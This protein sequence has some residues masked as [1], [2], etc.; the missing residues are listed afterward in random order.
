MGN[1]VYRNIQAKGDR[2]GGGAR[3][4][5]SILYCSALCPL[6]HDRSSAPSLPSP[7]NQKPFPIPF[8]PQRDIRDIVR[9]G[10]PHQKRVPERHENRDSDKS[11]QRAADREGKEGPCVSV[12]AAPGPGCTR[13][14]RQTDRSSH[15]TRHTTTLR[16]GTPGQTVTCGHSQHVLHSFSKHLRPV[17]H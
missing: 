3:K 2:W 15:P 5:F 11:E 12:H 13:S 17:P 9:R 16:S 8:Q 4:P 14:C 6:S 10:N 1:L 7:S